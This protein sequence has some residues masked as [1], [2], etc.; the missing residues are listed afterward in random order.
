MVRSFSVLDITYIGVVGLIV[1]KILKKKMKKEKERKRKE[2]KG[3]AKCLIYY[4]Y[5]M[6]VGM[7]CLNSAC[8]SIV[9]PP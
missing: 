6:Y 5:Y 3:K 4:Y 8:L 2:R 1:I 7:S 9:S